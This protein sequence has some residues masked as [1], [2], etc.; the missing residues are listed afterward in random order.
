MRDPKAMTLGELM[1]SSIPSVRMNVY[2]IMHAIAIQA[3]EDQKRPV[4]LESAMSPP[5]YQETP[6]PLT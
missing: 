1:E 6:R 3:L 4:S 2:V 5:L